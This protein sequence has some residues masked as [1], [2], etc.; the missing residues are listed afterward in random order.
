MKKQTFF[1]LFLFI[2][3]NL[4]GQIIDS[5]Q[6][7]FSERVLF[8]FGKYELTNES[9]SILQ[10]IVL[11]IDTNRQYRIALR[12]H[13]D[14]IGSTEKNIE[15]SQQR[16]N[17]VKIGL[18]AKGIQP[19]IIKIAAFGEHQPKADN[20][21]ETGRQLNRRATIDVFQIK[22][23]LRINGQVVN[24]NTQRKIVADIVFRSKETKDSIQTDTQGHF[25]TFL[26]LGAVVGMDVFAKGY[27]FETR[28]FKVQPNSKEDFK[29]SL[30][31]AIVGA[32][33]KLDNFYFVGNKAILLKRSLPELPKLLQFMQLNDS[34]KIEIAGH[35]NRPNYPPVDK[36]SWEFKLSERRAKMVYDFLLR[37][38]I[39][40]ERI[41]YK[42]YGNFQ[43]V[44]PEAKT[45]KQQALNRRVEIKIIE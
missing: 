24:E 35:I 13:T 32:K 34:L 3:T 38:K 28:M 26:P 36:L 18:V 6:L 45:E 44:Y 14:A 37:H 8:D 11:R 41:S 7:I 15:L 2:S 23:M 16:A 29:F 17:A 1:T 25:S 27:F 19:E 9:D 4:L 22:K 20:E 43:M 31:E 30:K 40:K 33:M 12:A 5:A 10:N 39:A 21:T 42:G